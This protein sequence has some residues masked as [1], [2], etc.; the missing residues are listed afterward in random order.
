MRLGRKDGQLSSKIDAATTQ[1]IGSFPRKLTSG[2]IVGN[3]NDW[4]VVENKKEARKQAT[5]K[6]NKRKEKEQHNIATQNQYQSLESNAIQTEN[7]SME[8]EATKDQHEQ[9]KHD[10]EKR[11]DT[12]ANKD[13]Q[14][15][16]HIIETSNNQKT[17]VLN[18]VEISTEVELAKV[19]SG[20]NQEGGG[21]EIQNL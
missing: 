17:P 6:G 20:D 21:I 19:K 8:I 3:P 15:E 18:D 10:G 1:P 11:E 2:K 16:T 4:N 12:E 7:T 5:G 14:K 13:E 9:Q